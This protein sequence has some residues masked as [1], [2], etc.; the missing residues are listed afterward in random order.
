MVCLFET[1]PGCTSIFPALYQYHFMGPVILRLGLGIVFFIHG[2]QKLF[3]GIEPTT[4][5]FASVGIHPARFFAYF[6]GLIE[7]VGAIFL[8][9]GLFV[10]LV[11]LLLAAVMVVAI[12][13][14]K[15][16]RGFIGG[17]DLEL[18]LLMMALS[19]ALL[20]PGAYALD[21]PF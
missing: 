5:F 9:A 6:V 12:W 3:G 4:Q 2:Y 13:R 18:M 1:I 10:Q 16:S 7:F 20:G 21:M 19:L 15:Y 17:Y 8:F 11:A 14:V